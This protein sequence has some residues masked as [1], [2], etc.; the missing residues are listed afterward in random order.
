MRACTHVSSAIEYDLLCYLITGAIFTSF[1]YVSVASLVLVIGELPQTQIQ[2]WVA[3]LLLDPQWAPWMVP[4]LV[5][6]LMDLHL[7]IFIRQG[8]LGALL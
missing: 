7:L 6:A 5:E 4:F 1:V 8:D 3:C 2:G